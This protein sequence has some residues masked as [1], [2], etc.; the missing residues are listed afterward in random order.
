MAARSWVWCV[1]ATIAVALLLVYGVPSASA[2]RKKEVRTLFSATRAFPNEWGFRGSVLS[3]LTPF[4][5]GSV[6]GAS[7]SAVLGVGGFAREETNPLCSGDVE[8][9]SGVGYVTPW[10]L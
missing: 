3:F 2:Q 1:S 4:P 8:C 6:L 7:N 10:L 9:E 5:A